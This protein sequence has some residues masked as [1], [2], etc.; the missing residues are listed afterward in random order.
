MNHS[1]EYIDII[2]LA[3]IAGFIFLRLRGILG[4]R[5]GYEG[6][7]KEAFVPIIDNDKCKNSSR[8]MFHDLT[9]NMICAGYLK[10]GGTD[11]CQGDSG[12]PLACPSGNG[13]VYVLQGVISWGYDCGAAN[14]PGVYTRVSQFVPWIQ[15]TAAALTAAH[16]S[17]QSGTTPYGINVG[18]L[19]G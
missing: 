2:L 12:G 11:S 17:Y 14:A 6:K 15:Q 13:N 10:S 8:R 3:M 9:E 4:K 5:T 1:L 18:S 16:Q 7:L 19:Y